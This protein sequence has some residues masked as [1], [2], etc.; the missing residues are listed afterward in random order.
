MGFV[1]IRAFAT[2]AP[3][4]TVVQVPINVQNAPTPP[5]IGG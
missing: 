1:I 4:T 5:P 2:A 3:T